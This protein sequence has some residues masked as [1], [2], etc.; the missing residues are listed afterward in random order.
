M[1]SMTSDAVVTRGDDMRRA[2][3]MGV[4]GCLLLVGL[5]GCVLFP[6]SEKLWGPALDVEVTDRY[7]VVC[8]GSA[9]VLVDGTDPEAPRALGEVEV[10]ARAVALRGDLA[11]VAAGEDG[12]RAVDV[13][14]PHQAKPLGGAPTRFFARAVAVTGDHVI[15]G[16]DTTLEI[17]DVSEPARPRPVASLPHPDGV[18]DI[19][20]SGDLAYVEGREAVRILDVSDPA[21]PVDVGEYR[22]S[23]SRWRPVNGIDIA[24]DRLFVTDDEAIHV[25]DVSRPDTP[26]QLAL[27]EIPGPSHPNPSAV[28]VSGS[29]ACV[30]DV[31]G[32]EQ[33]LL[34]LDVTLPDPPRLLG[35]LTT[36]EDVHTRIASIDA[37]GD[38][39][40][41]ALSLG[42]LWIV[43]FSDPSSP[44]VAGRFKT[45]SLRD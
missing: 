33:R 40:Y 41:V 30:S 37:V 23:D 34:V 8:A 26:T 17:F 15:V 29:R 32:F 44:K 20:V 16:G 19:R 5:A 45:S 27:A 10:A 25:V 7:A 4:P 21:N 42:G 36:G 35:S 9:L 24:E 6:G 11:F 39:A 13:S 43:D 31:S 14:N 3:W 2:S 1:L 22:T 38:R 18:D 28:A 12:L